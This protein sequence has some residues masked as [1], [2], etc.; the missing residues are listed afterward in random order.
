MPWRW[1][2]WP[3]GFDASMQCKAF[4]IFDL[5]CHLQRKRKEKKEEKEEKEEKKEKKEKREK[6]EKR[7][8]EKKEKN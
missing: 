3:P 5:S 6:R 4:V 2:Q 7:E 1:I 8:K